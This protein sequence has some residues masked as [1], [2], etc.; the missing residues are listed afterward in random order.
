MGIVPFTIFTSPSKLSLS[1]ATRNKMLES[2]RVMCQFRLVQ[3]IPPTPQN[4][5]ELR[6]IELRGRTGEDWPKIHA[7]YANI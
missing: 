2:D 4:L 6:K 5:D 7:K 1:I 3:N